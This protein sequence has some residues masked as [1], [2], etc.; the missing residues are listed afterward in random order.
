MKNTEARVTTR[1]Y[2]A[3]RAAAQEQANATGFDVG[4]ERSA[5]TG[6]YTAR[7]LPARQNRYGHELW[8]EVVSCEDLARCQ[9][10]HGP[11]R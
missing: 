11:V 8:C 3:V 2:A 7:L 6:E 1:D 4:L 5:R 10:G 9:P